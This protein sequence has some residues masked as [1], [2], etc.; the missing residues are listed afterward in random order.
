MSREAASCRP[1]PGA[2]VRARKPKK[3][4]YIPRPWGKPYKYK[5][6]QCPFT[7]LE[8]SHL[9]NHMK[10]SLCKNSLS[11]LLDSPDWAC[12]RTPAT[13]RPRVPTPDHSLDPMD[14]GSSQMLPDA[15]ANPN[16]ITDV[17]SLHHHVRGPGVG[18]EGSPGTPPP[19]A[20]DA[21]KGAGL[22]RLLA[23]PWKPELGGGPRCKVV[24]D[25]AATGSERGVPCYP[26]PTPSELPETQSLH[27]SLLGINYPLS[28]G[29]FSY[30]GPSLAAAAHMPFLASAGPLL[31]PTTTFPAPQPPER[32]T[33]VP[34]LCYPL[35]LEHTLGLATGRAAPG[36]PPAT[37]KGPPGTLAPDLLEMPITGLGRPWPQ[38]DRGQEWAAQSDPKKK[39]PLGSRLEPQR[40][41]SSTV[42]FGSQSSLR[43]GPSMMLWAEDKEPGDPE[44]P[45]SRVP[46]PSQ[47]L[48][49]EPGGP[50]HVS[51][52]LTQALG[53]YARVEQRLGQLAPA[54]GLAPR[55]LWEQL[56]KIREE[57]FTIHQAL[58][59][60]VWPPDT[61]LDLSVKRAP[62]KGPKGPAG[63]WGLPGLGPTLAQ[64]TP[65]PPSM[66]GPTAE[67]FSSRATKCEAD[68]SVPPPGLP[69][70]APQDPIVPGSSWGSR[71][72]DGG[73]WC[74]EAVLPGAEV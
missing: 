13:S 56:G 28:P 65:E 10:Y 30:L 43:T 72:G 20:R 4:H 3:P 33:L 24:V 12:R 17:L 14:P 70:Q 29:L 7:C 64:G 55:P 47:P 71:G 69:L 16:L 48:G 38:G 44:T 57:L 23:E 60:A 45:G 9:Y 73:P 50:G 2:R 6:F 36:K 11:L 34:S 37:P 58:E 22:G 5:C 51:E 66:L 31:P 63:A 42:K 15:P 46:L 18:A 27:L 25:A 35:L 32:P 54:G 52:D 8:K 68:S 26:P 19:A 40:A 53:D 39:L 1:G 59:R 49:L 21:Q 62:T 41:P 67:A 74:P 61:P